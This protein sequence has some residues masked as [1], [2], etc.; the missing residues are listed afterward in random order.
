MRAKTVGNVPEEEV[1]AA[2]KAAK[3]GR[4]EAEAIFELT[5]KPTFQERFVLPPLARELQI[6][7]T[8]DPYRRKQEAGFGF[9]RPGER[10]F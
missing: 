3:L 1:E 4:E 9:R 6:E 5:S 10:R 2:L 7:A 8:E